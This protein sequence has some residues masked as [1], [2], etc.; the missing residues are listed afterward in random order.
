MKLESQNNACSSKQWQGSN[1][2]SLNKWKFIF[3]ETLKIVEDGI[4]NDATCFTQ[5]LIEI[6]C[7]IVISDVKQT[8]CHRI[9]QRREKK[10]TQQQINYYY[11]LFSLHTLCACITHHEFDKNISRTVDA[12]AIFVTV[13]ISFLH[14]TDAICVRAYWVYKKKHAQNAKH[15]LERLSTM[16]KKH[17]NTFT[18][19]YSQ[20]YQKNTKPMSLYVE[21][22]AAVRWICLYT[23]MRINEMMSYIRSNILSARNNTK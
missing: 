18:Y 9:E 19:A 6:Y 23:I 10:A 4:E 21:D 8:R 5:C 11:L 3:S 17:T 2:S 7:K 15:T 14:F 1:H 22:D 13:K 16:K 12:I 20:Q